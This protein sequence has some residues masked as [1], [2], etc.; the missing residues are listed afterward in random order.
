[1]TGVQNSNSHIATMTLMR[2]YRSLVLL[3]SPLEPFPVKPKQSASCSTSCATLTWVSNFTPYIGGGIGVA[4]IDHDIIGTNAPNSIGYG[5]N[6]RT[7]AYQGIAGVAVELAENLALDLSYRYFGTTKENVD[8]TLNGGPA[9]FAVGY[10]SHSFFGG[11]RWNFGP[12][13]PAAPQYKDCW[14]G[15]SVPVSAQ[16]PP[17]LVED[18]TADLD[19]INFT[20]Y[21]DYDKSNLTSQAST[22]IQEAAGRAAGNDISSVVVQGNADRSGNSAYNQGLSER[23]AGVVSD[24]LVANGVDGDDIST[25]A[26]GEDNPAKP[27]ADGVREPLNRRTD[28]TINFE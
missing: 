20:V 16:C 26:F 22:L 3:V 2:S 14:D 12:S 6:K 24:A 17:Q 13:A 18:A 28:V 27:T 4:D 9:S 11:L 10:A 23:R 19:P 5:P 8:G 21:F 7:F 25:E 1:M 15:S